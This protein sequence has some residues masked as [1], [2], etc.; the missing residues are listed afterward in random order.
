[1]TTK[2]LISLMTT[3]TLLCSSLIATCCWWNRTRPIETMQ[4]RKS[5]EV[6]PSNS[7]IEAN[8]DKFAAI[9]RDNGIEHDYTPF[10]VLEIKTSIDMDQH[11]MTEAL[12]KTLIMNT[13]TQ[14]RARY[15]IPPD[16]NII[17]YEITSKLI[18]LDEFS[19]T[20]YHFH[21]NDGIDTT[22]THYYEAQV[23]QSRYFEN[24]VIKD[25]RLMVLRVVR[26]IPYNMNTTIAITNIDAAINLSLFQGVFSEISIADITDS[27]WYYCQG[28]K[29]IILDNIHSFFINPPPNLTANDITICHLG[30]KSTSLLYNHIFI[31]IKRIYLEGRIVEAELKAHAPLMFHRSCCAYDNEVDYEDEYCF[32]IGNGKYYKEYEDEIISFLS[33]PLNIISNIDK[34]TSTVPLIAHLSKVSFDHIEGN[35]IYYIVEYDKQF[36]Y[37]LEK[38]C[39][40]TLSKPQRLCVTISGYT[41]NQIEQAAPQMLV[42]EPQQ[43]VP[44]KTL[45]THKPKNQLWAWIG[46]GLGALVIMAISVVLIKSYLKHKNAV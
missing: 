43:E 20:Q 25:N 5:I 7:M 6:Q 46:V 16:A 27:M 24:D 11:Q 3:T 22:P 21:T 28:V 32:E 29:K 2:R 23:L 14:N 36:S 34:K 4:T 12:I 8:A 30:D 39:Y 33:N 31:A 26:V 10:S 35:D 37:N 13:L 44:S 45:P 17:V 40:F 41:T 1:M 9:L 19:G 42:L 18:R 38:E 15:R